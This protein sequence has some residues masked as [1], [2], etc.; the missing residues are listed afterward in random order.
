M[1]IKL[2]ICLLVFLIVISGC[3]NTR[4]LTRDQMLYT[5]RQNVEII[6]THKLSNISSVKNYVKSTTDHKVNN[7][8][9]GKRILPP[10]GLWVH[11]YLKPKEGKKL[12]RWFYKTFSSY[13]ILISDVNPELRSAKIGNDLFDRGYFNTKAW[14]VI[15]TSKRNPKKGKISYFVD[16]SPPSFYD[17]ISIDTIAD[18][19]D[20]LIY[21]DEF[22]KQIKPGD[23]FNLENLRNSRTELSR[24]IQ[25]HGYYYFIPEFIDL[26]ADT[27]E[28]SNR[29]NL[30]VAGRKDLPASVLSKYKINNIS[31]KN[32]QGKDTI[33]S[34]KYTT[35]Y[36][37]IKVSS[38]GDILKPNILANS[39]YFREG[40]IYSY[41]AYQ[42]TTTRLNNL[43]VFKSVNVSYIKNISDSLAHLLDVEMD[44][45]MADNINLAFEADLATKSS[46]YF[47]PLFSVSI[48]HGNAFKG[49]ER[50]KLGLTGGFEWQW[51]SKS[52]TQI[53]NYSYQIGITSG[54]TFPRIIL[55]F[56][57]GKNSSKLFQRTNINLDLSLLNR[58]AYYKMFSAKTNLNYQWSSKKNI[59]HSFSPIYVN[60]VNVLQT[61]PEFDSV[62]NENIY[63]RKSFEEQFIIGSKYD[64]TFNN[65]LLVKPN[66]FYFQA[67]I[68]TSGNFVDLFAGIG[69]DPSER[70]YYFS[71][72][73]YSQ[74]LKFTTDFR[75]YRNGFNKSLVFRLYAGIGV[76]YGNS[77]ALPYVEQFFSGGA[78]SLRGFTARYLGPGSYHS[79]DN[80]GY[81][82]QSGDIKLE[83]N[84]EFRFDMSKLLK[85][86]IFLETGNIWLVNEDENRPGAKFNKN[87]FIDEL[88]VDTGFGFRFDFTFFVMRLDIGFPLRTPYETDGKNWLRGTDNVLSGALFNLAIGY[89]F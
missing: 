71:N 63:I 68:S 81:I 11:N 61:T 36:E 2:P 16:L 12:A 54:L 55:P 52:N 45:I 48:A 50:L 35:V 85:G 47:G 74:Y 4:L 31:I 38:T 86:A 19:I 33:F 14:A 58:A 69:K 18:P 51:G 46:G 6:N 17:K 23:Q 40:D 49:A 84:L 5:G 88:A 83:S 43:G 13:P 73:I 65:T 37:G 67:G 80:S 75:Y 29:V 89:P 9:F 27:T 57:I 82:D 15:D 26:K 34:E 39:V 66:N 24:R 21:E 30:T 70:P 64:F 60:S 78:Y 41:S 53:S 22:M 44:L 56:K 7:S 42:K 76:P 87:T 62:V 59:Q 79:S 20:S 32:S 25:E 28:G 10:L 1:R 3:S 8:L 77:D 72:N